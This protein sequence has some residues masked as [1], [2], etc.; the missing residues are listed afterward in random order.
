M[1]GFVGI[2]RQG[3]PGNLPH[4]IRQKTLHNRK[5]VVNSA[6]GA[7]LMIEI[8]STLPLWSQIQV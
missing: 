6:T 2:P 4:T 5:P 7:K 3:H 8:Q 1:P